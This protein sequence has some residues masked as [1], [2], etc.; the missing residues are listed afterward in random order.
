MKNLLFISLIICF[1]TS[2]CKVYKSLKY[3]GL[4]SQKDY[5]HFPQRVV[6][7]AGSPFYFKQPTKNY[8][9][10]K[11]IGLTNRD[12]NST[13]IQLDN[14]VNLHKTISFLII[15]NDTI[16]Y[17][18]YKRKYTDTTLVSSFSMVKPII[19]TLIGIAIDEGKIKSIDDKIIN[20][21]PEFRNKAGW[22]KISIKN[23]LHHTSGIK[24]ND[25][26]INPLSDNAKFYW[27]DN[28]RK[29]MLGLTLECAPDLKFKYSSENTQLLGFILEKV[30]G[31]S[32]SNYLQEKLWKPLEMESPAYWSLDRKDDKGMEKAFCCLQA[33][34]VDFAKIGKLYLNNGKW[35]GNQIVSEK[36]VKYSTKADATGNNKHYYNNNWGIGPEK[37]GSFYAVGLYGQYLYIHPEKKLIIVRFGDTELNY[38][39]NYWNETF[40]QL[41]DQI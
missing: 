7:N 28:L 3:G 2:S 26:K 29:E 38:R 19:S 6:Y 14:F 35:N 25:N 27:G 10:G 39:P 9:L 31:H 40:L 1:G 41:I 24:F 36:W 32:I 21:L 33:R 18:S 34:A 23:L 8:D 5:K 22:E 16:L 20:Y 4:P 30:T 15:R 11:T 37:Y 17:E 12:L 13:N